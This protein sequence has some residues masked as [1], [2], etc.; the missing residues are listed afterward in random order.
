VVY[1]A[2]V[3]L[4]RR[5]NRPIYRGTLTF[6]V[7]ILNHRQP[8]AL[9]QSPAARNSA[10]PMP[11]PRSRGDTLISHSTATSS[12]P[13]HERPRAQEAVPMQ[14]RSTVSKPP[15]RPPYS[16]G[17]TLPRTVR[18]TECIAA[19]SGVRVVDAVRAAGTPKRSLS[20]L[21]GP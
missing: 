17:E 19:R 11:L 20:R 10:D 1:A 18:V 21:P 12:R 5:C 2:D 4:K 9:A 6:W 15:H 14:Q 16:W 8:R 7:S 13:R 3:A